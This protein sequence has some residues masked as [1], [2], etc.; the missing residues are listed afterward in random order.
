YLNILHAGWPAGLVLGGLIVFGKG[1][2]G[3][4]LLMATFL[5]PT[6]IYGFFTIT[7][8]FPET[9]AQSGTVSYGDMLIK[10]IAPF[11]I[12]LLL[13]HALVG[14]VE[15]GT[16]SWINKITGTILNNAALGTVLFIYTSILMTALRFF[17]GPIVERISSLGL[18]LGS[19]VLGALG[20]YLISLGGSIPFMFFACT[21]YAF[22][23]T[24]LWP[25]MLG[26]AGERYPSSVTVAMALMG[27]VGML[28]A[29]FLGGP[30]IGYKQDYFA[31]QQLKEESPETYERVKADGDSQFLFFPSIVGINGAKA[32]MIA[33]GGEKIT[34]EKTIAGDN[35]SSDTYS[36]LR[37]QYDWYESNKEMAA[38][39]KEPLASAELF[40]SKMAIRWTAIIPASMAVLYIILLCFPAPKH[41][42]E[43]ADGSSIAEDADLAKASD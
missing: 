26:V 36:M 35:W 7:E 11:F 2:V 28:S 17:A 33:D 32:G 42:E 37:E 21:V 4:E 39:D 34:S 23:K 15:L 27:A 14:Y 5:I 6:I 8:A 3:W 25:T 9:E 40:G 10:I 31:S 20:L 22:G 12:I 29:G 43:D 24:F 18:L 41:K 38:E 19:A 30:G 1:Y 16:D 13:A